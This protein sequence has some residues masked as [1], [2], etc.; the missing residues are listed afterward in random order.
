MDT[1]QPQ[2]GAVVGGFEGSARPSEAAASE[3]GEGI[4]KS[5]GPIKVSK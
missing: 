3:R 1:A 4:Y 5:M 2:L